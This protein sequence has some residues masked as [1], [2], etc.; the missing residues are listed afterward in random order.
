M[1][2]G[3]ADYTLDI[4]VAAQQEMFKSHSLLLL[5][6]PAG[7]VGIVAGNGAKSDWWKGL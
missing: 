6:T 5:G 2:P 4:D 3:P 7:S 1:H